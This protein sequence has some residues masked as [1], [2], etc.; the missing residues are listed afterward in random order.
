M[1]TGTRD[2]DVALAAARHQLPGPPQDDFPCSSRRSSGHYRSAKTPVSRCSRRS[3][4][5]R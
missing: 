2:V 4:G 3:A 1:S 5:S